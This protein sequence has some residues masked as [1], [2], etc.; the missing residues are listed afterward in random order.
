ML[1]QL[2]DPLLRRPLFCLAVLWAGGIML[3]AQVPVAVTAWAM[4][5]GGS[6]LAWGIRVLH[7]RNGAMALCVAVLTLSA[8][9][10]AWRLA[11]PGPGDPRALPV[12]RL[13]V[14][15]YPL[16]PAVRTDYGWHVPFRLRARQV[17]EHWVDAAGAVYLTGKDMP[18]T[19]GT[20]WRVAGQVRPAEEA[21]NPFGF[22]QRAYLAESDLTAVLR[23]ESLTPYALPAPASSSYAIRAHLH[24][25]LMATM[26]PTYG[27]LYAQLLDSLILGVY[28][29][30]L[31]KALTEQFRLAGTIH[32]MVV[33]GSQI[34]LLGSL[35]LFPL[36]LASS[37]RMATTYPRLRVALLLLSL[38]LLGGYVALADRGPS[39]DR[40]LLMGLLATLAVF[41]ALSPL[42]RRRAF[43]PDGLTLLGAAA[44]VILISRPAALFG[45]GMQLSFAAVFGLLTLT[46]LFMRLLHRRLGPFA[47]LIAATLGAQLM[48][49]PVLAWHFGAIPLLGPL[50]NLIAVPVVALL[51]PLGLLTLLFAIFC[52]PLAMLMNSLLNVPLLKILLWVNA[53]AARVPFASVPVVVRSPGLI[54]LY[55]GI[56]T[57]GGLL[58]SHWLDSRAEDWSVPAG[59]EPAMW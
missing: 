55:L 16:G 25:R 50:T 15:G 22:N 44:L 53:T 26:P 35:L 6:L 32:L 23:A 10:A 43:H 40:A 36:W 57:V 34:T 56:L 7:G 28:G 24:A 45:P 2:L 19:P 29:S 52:P 30:P 8:A 48:T 41:L 20:H 21:G 51:L 27:P 13:T 3:A 54:L 39:V 42:A 1:A 46:P 18:P 38:P 11:P 47:L 17:G 58:L 33:S 31:P 4:L 5:A 9:L 37:G 14:I 59:R 49:F 12:G